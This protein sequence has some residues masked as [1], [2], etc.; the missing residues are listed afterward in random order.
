M[1]LV[2]VSLAVCCLRDGGDA[3]ELHAYMHKLRTLD[4]MDL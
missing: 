1:G 2:W 4:P 3:A